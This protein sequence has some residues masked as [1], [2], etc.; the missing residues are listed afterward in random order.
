MVTSSQ[1]LEPRLLGPV[2]KQVQKVEML[3]TLSDGSW[4]PALWK[5]ESQALQGVL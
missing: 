3:A 1:A 2:R 5:L 4:E